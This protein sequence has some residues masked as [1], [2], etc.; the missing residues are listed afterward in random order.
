MRGRRMSEVAIISLF[1]RQRHD[2]PAKV[3]DKSRSRRGD[4]PATDIPEPAGIAAPQLQQ[5][6][7]DADNQ[8]FL[9]KRSCKVQRMQI[10]SLLEHQP[11]L[12]APHLLYRKIGKLRQRPHLLASQVISIYVILPVP[13]AP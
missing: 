8:S 11:A 4:I 12:A 10:S 6:G 3:N 7:R 5:I 1:R 2:I 9:N 13:V